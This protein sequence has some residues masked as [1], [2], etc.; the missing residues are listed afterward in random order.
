MSPRLIKIVVRGSRDATLVQ[1]DSKM[2]AS[3]TVNGALARLV[4]S[5]ERALRDYGGRLQSSHAVPQ[6]EEINSEHMVQL[7]G[8]LYG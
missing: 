7:S 6:R 8:S 3:A 2:R 4:L 1:G 5:R